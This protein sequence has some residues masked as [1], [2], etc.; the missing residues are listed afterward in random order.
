MK[1][2]ALKENMFEKGIYNC[3][4]VIAL[5]ISHEI[6]ENFKATL[7]AANNAYLSLENSTRLRKNKK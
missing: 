3:E 2:K 4:F 5:I 7:L 6:V 1:V